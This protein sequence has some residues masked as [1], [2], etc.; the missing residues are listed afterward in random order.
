MKNLKSQ[1]RYVKD[2]IPNIDQVDLE[3]DEVLKQ[4]IAECQG[5]GISPSNI[6]HLRYLRRFLHKTSDIAT[7][8]LKTALEV[9]AEVG[10]GPASF[11]TSSLSASASTS[12]PLR[13]ERSFLM[14]GD[15]GIAEDIC[16]VVHFQLKIIS[17]FSDERL[18]IDD[19]ESV[20]PP[21]SPI[22]SGIRIIND[23]DDSGGKYL[24][25]IG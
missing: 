25:I 6:K 23:K 24:A 18:V 13:L 21:T 2:R 14:S 1:Y 4:L 16:I 8:Q 12:R 10:L 5:R 22:S 7:G 3:D 15:P 17:Q 9:R 11:N 20:S 19:G